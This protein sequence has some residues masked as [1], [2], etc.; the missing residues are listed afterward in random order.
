[1]KS[2]KLEKN[3]SPKQ[4]FITGIISII[5]SIIFY[6]GVLG[7][8]FMTIAIASFGMSLWIY[9]KNKGNLIIQIIGFLLLGLFTLILGIFVIS[10]FQGFLS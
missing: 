2:F 5:S 1:M 10:F 3:V 4:Y 7:S 6:S 8:L 9:G